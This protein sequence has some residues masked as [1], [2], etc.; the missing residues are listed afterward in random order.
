MT[1]NKLLFANSKLNISTFDAVPGRAPRSWFSISTSK[2]LDVRGRYAQ[3]NLLSHTTSTS[4]TATST[5]VTPAVNGGGSA[6]RGSAV[7]MLRTDEYIRVGIDPYSYL[8]HS[9]PQLRT[10]NDVFYAVANTVVV[11]QRGDR[12]S[13]LCDQVTMVPYTEAWLTCAMACVDAGWKVY[14]RADGRQHAYSTMLL[15]QGIHRRLLERA[16]SEVV[17]YDHDLVKKVFALHGATHSM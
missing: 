16:H 7:R 8:H 17:A 5:T 13:V 6:V 1:E 15:C 4:T 3:W 10:A 14:A 2:V 12:Q 11:S 9:I